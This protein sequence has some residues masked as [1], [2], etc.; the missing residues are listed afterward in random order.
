MGKYILKRFLISLATLLVILFILFLMLELMP[1]SPFN[2]EKITEAQRILLDAKYGLNQPLIVRF[3]NYAK[4]MLQGDFGV[5]YVINKNFPVSAMVFDRLMITI[6]IGFQAMFLGSLVGLVLGV[7]AALNHNT[8]IDTACSAIS[9]I[10]VSVPSYVFA[11]G[12]A[13]FIGF[14]LNLFPILYNINKP[15]LSSVLPTVSLSLFTIANI[16][17][18]TRSEMI[19]VLNSD[20]IQLAMSKG[21]KNWKLVIKHALRNTL[22]PIITVMGP[23]LVGLLTG[24]MVIEKIFAI[25]GVGSL[26]VNAIQNNDYNVVITC[27]FIYSA[28]Y[29]FTMLFVDIMYG[30][31]DPRVRVTKRG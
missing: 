31:I 27:A 13:Y 20:Y 6:R 29:I 14:K 3:F 4:N 5:S 22:I 12:L 28:L 30:V 25:P 17:R 7:I 1:G 19:D 23:L 15:S 9:I 11:L 24:S 8:W 21:I 26:M 2:D 18:F 16:A 10:G